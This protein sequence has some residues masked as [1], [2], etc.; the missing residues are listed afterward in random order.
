MTLI[1]QRWCAFLLGAVIVTATAGA[2]VLWQSTRPQP[3]MVILMIGDGMGSGQ[4][5]AARQSVPGGKLNLERLSQSGLATTHSADNLVTDSAAAATALATGWKTNN[6]MVGVSPDGSSL[7]TVLERAEDFGMATGLVT[8]TRVTHATPAAFAAHVV[9]RN[10]EAE[11][12]QQ[13]AA[14]GVDVAMGGGRAYFLPLSAE[15][16]L[17]ADEEELLQDV[18]AGGYQYLQSRDDLLAANRS[19]QVVGLF[20]MDHM[21]YELERDGEV[22]PSLAEM[23]DFALTVLSGD[24][25]GFFLMVEGGR[26]DHAGHAN[27]LTNTIGDTLAFDRAVGIGLNFTREMPRALL[28]VTGD[29]ETGGLSILSTPPGGPMSVAWTTM[30][31]T[32]NPVP[33]YSEGYTASLLRGDIDNTEIGLRLLQL[34]EESRRMPPLVDD[35]FQGP[36][37]LH[38]AT[39][40]ETRGKALDVRAMVADVRLP[41]L[42]PISPR[43]P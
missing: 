34:L 28:V 5:A 27:N 12:A 42:S 21:S 26:I 4:V 7:V 17:R 40:S 19:G 43:F 39:T 22:E 15:G 25:D 8:T 13:L 23:T 10:M 36:E 41:A 32:G 38:P 30:G 9:D 1:R 37:A 29:H 16:S 3:L 11:I 24:P 31:H 35:P 6:G 2:I 33:L 18:T 14:S 20:A